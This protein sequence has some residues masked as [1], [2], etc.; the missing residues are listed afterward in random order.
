MKRLYS[1]LVLIGP[2][3]LYSGCREPR[4]ENC[5][6]LEVNDPKIIEFAN[7]YAARYFNL[8]LFH[9]PKVSL[10]D[11]TE[12]CVIKIIY[13]GKSGDLFDYFGIDIQRDTCNARRILTM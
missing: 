9:P 4:L 2:I 5:G 3:F 8:S 6:A 7:A 11:R 12:N 13:G 10:C 1:L